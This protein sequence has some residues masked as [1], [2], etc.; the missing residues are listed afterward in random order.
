MTSSNKMCYKRL[1]G[2]LA[3]IKK[4]SLS[5][6][7]I[8]PTSNMLIWNAEIKGPS[9]TPYENGIFKLN[10]R[11]TE[12]YPIKPPSVKFSEPAKIFHPNIYRDGKICVD[13]LQKEWS[14]A[15]NIRSILISI[16]SLLNDPNPNS[17][18]NRDAAKLFVSNFNEYCKI[19]KKQMLK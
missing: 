2:E 12:E 1:A 4:K 6:V 7:K 19:V 15:Q 18:A 11:F 14:P 16:M 13:I 5:G 10:L 9:E 3:R 17:P 8:E